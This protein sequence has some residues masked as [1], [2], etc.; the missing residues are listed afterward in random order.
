MLNR[1]ISTFSTITSKKGLAGEIAIRLDTFCV[2]E[3]LQSLAIAVN[4]GLGNMSSSAFNLLSIHWIHTG[5]IT[6][7]LTNQLK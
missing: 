6:R 2:L 4:S 7:L 5:R 1:G 3:F